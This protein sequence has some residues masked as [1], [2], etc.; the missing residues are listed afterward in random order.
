M[1]LVLRQCYN[2]N[3]KPK[4]AENYNAQLPEL[5]EVL[6]NIYGRLEKNQPDFSTLNLT[7]KNS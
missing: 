4:K 3:N 6:S 2:K 5:Q 1:K 7:A